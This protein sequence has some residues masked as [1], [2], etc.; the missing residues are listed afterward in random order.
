[1]KKILVIFEGN[2]YEQAFNLIVEKSFMR[3]INNK[4]RRSVVV[5]RKRKNMLVKLCMTFFF[6]P[7]FYFLPW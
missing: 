5:Y 1:M 4:F 7:I 3:K 6:F 2:K